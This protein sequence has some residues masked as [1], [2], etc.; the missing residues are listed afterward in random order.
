MD[1]KSV[2]GAWGDRWMECWWDVPEDPLEE[3]SLNRGVMP[4]MMLG[5]LNV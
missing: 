5:C 4:H 3:A 1:M 2:L